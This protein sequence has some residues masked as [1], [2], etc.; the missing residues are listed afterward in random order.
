MAALCSTL[1]LSIGVVI[2]AGSWTAP[3]YDNGETA[4]TLTPRTAVDSLGRFTVSFRLDFICELAESLG[5]R[6]SSDSS[7]SALRWCLSRSLS[8][9][10]ALSRSR[11]LSLSFRS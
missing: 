7:L 8:L 10:L 4:W 11:L 6:L 9:S 3:E 2:D 1:S 5:Q